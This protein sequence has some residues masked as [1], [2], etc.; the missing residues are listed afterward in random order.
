MT[1][2]TEAEVNL[3]DMAREP[4]IAPLHPALRTADDVLVRLH[5][6]LIVHLLLGSRAAGDV[7]LAREFGHEALS[8]QLEVPLV[9]TNPAGMD[10]LV[11]HRVEDRILGGMLAEGL[12]EP[13]SEAAST[14]VRA[15]PP[16]TADALIVEDIDL[17]EVS[18]WQAGRLNVLI[19]F[20]IEIFK[21]GSRGHVCPFLIWQHYITGASPCQQK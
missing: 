8:G 14:V 6:L 21:S 10:Q 19:G 5:H 18:Y 7:V 1:L 2:G 3:L 17:V 12:G 16:D 15:V 9:A 4:L 11:D 20:K 13:D